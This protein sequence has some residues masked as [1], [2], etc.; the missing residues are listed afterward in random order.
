[1]TLKR[2][3]YAAFLIPSPTTFEHNSERRSMMRHLSVLLL[4]PSLCFYAGTAL[5]GKPPL[6]CGKKSLAVAVENASNESISF[7]GVCSGPI[8]IQSDGVSLIGVGIAVIDGNGQ[9]AVTVAGAH[10][11][12]LANIEVRN[13]A[14]GI[15]GTNGAH[16]SLKD[17]N[18]HDNQLFGISLQTGS[19]ANLSGVSVSVNGLHG[20]DMETGSAANISGKFTSSDNDVFG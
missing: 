13:G 18:V 17:V 8:V 15:L 7:T 19:S 2:P 14:N 4:A 6:N 11:V 9:D 10:G 16:L 1:M 3:E 5:A 12:S 20:L